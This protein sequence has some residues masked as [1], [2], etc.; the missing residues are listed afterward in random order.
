MFSG[1]DTRGGASP[2]V[3]ASHEDCHIHHAQEIFAAGPQFER[4]YIM[5]CLD[6]GSVAS[7]FG[8][9]KNECKLS[10][11]PA[12]VWS[13]AWVHNPLATSRRSCGD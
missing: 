7:H 11:S 13:T 9:I 2:V 5:R 10:S 4:R 8:Q 1:A 6:S 12:L 3:N